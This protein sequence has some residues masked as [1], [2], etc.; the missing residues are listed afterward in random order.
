MGC[1]CL[2]QT[3]LLF[4]ELS[5]AFEYHSRGWDAIGHFR[6][7]SK[8]IQ[9]PRSARRTE[10][11]ITPYRVRLYPSEQHLTLYNLNARSLNNKP[12]DFVDPVCDARA[13]LFTIC[14]T[15]PKDNI[16]QF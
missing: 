5:L 4:S 1:F 7:L 10:K 15:W 16:L 9:R 6:M 3:A 14:D 13:D 11:L 8:V 12:A 2:C